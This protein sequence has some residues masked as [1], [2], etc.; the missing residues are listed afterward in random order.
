MSVKKYTSIQVL[1]SAIVLAC[2]SSHAH[3]DGAAKVGFDYDSC[4]L[5]A[6]SISALQNCEQ[7]RLADVEA[8]LS[9]TYRKTMAA[10]Q[11]DQQERLRAS[12]REWV[13]FRKADCEEVASQDV[14]AIAAVN[15]DHC[16]VQRT[17][18]HLS[19]LQGMPRTMS[20][21]AR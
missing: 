8:Q 16:L 18:Q 19:E 6:K 17:E 21:A 15:G 9:S 10:M 2:L 12:E 11:T 13:A 4:R 20:T 14:G 3:A 1:A 7:A 5:G